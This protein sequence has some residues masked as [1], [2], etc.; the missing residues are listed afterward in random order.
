MRRGGLEQNKGVKMSGGVEWVKYPASQR[1]LCPQPP[2]KCPVPTLGALNSPHK[3][4]RAHLGSCS[5]LRRR[6][7]GH[8]GCEEGGSVR[9]ELTGGGVVEQT[10]TPESFDLFFKI[11]RW[12]DRKHR[13]PGNGKA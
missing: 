12:Q 7:G 2:Q 5:L 4:R 1:P 13:R 10:Q 6:H 9:D 8:P 3:R 11:S